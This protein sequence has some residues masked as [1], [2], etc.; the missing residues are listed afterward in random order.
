MINKKYE[1]YDFAIVMSAIMSFI[2]SFVVTFINLG[3]IDEFILK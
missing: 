1:K 3:Y 2:M